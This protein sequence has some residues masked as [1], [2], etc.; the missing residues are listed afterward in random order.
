[1]CVSTSPEDCSPGSA[2]DSPRSRVY[3][4]DDNVVVDG[5]DDD[6]DNDV[7]L[8]H[9]DVGDDVVDDVVDDVDLVV[10]E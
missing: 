4:D 2:C 1:M 10:D 3:V 5:D 9:D 6:D 7:A 8:V